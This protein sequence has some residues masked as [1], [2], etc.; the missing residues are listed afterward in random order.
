[1]YLYVTEKINSYHKIGIADDVYNRINNFRT[2]I[3]D[4]NL[5]FYIPIPNRQMGELIER[6]LKNHLA[7][8]RFGKSECYGLEIQSIKNVIKGYTLLMNY[9]VI[10]YNI[11]PIG[12]S[13]QSQFDESRTPWAND[14]CYN[15]VIF[16]NEIYFG[17]KIP[18]FGIE[19]ISN[20]KIKIEVINKINSLDELGKLCFKIPDVFEGYNVS[21]KNYLYEYLKEYG[22]KEITIKQNTCAFIDYFSPI[23]WDALIKYLNF[24]RE[25]NLT[26]KVSPINKAHST[27]Y[28]NFPYGCLDGAKRNKDIKLSLMDTIN[29]S[30]LIDINKLTKIGNLFGQS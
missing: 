24:L 5:S 30:Y 19:K 20:D 3:P 27:V 2:L 9:C 29:R 21:L 16:L 22:T 23:V 15:S 11:N 4:I 25:I 18:L 28:E 7:V 17:E 13:E 8:Y 10:D 14:A 12:I 6:T 1:M 26:D